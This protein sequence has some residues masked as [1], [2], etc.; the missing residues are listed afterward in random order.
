MESYLEALRP[1]EPNSILILHACAHNPTGCDPTQDQW[2]EI[3]AVV[4][5][6]Q[7]F[8]LFD[9]A[10]LGFRSG[11][12]DKDAFSIRHFVNGL[13]LETAIAVSFAKNMGFY[14]ERVGATLFVTSTEEVAHKCES[15]LERLQRSEISN[16][17][18]Y[19]AKIAAEILGDSLLRNMW[20][21]DFKTMSD[22]IAAMRTSL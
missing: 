11:N 18:A 2:K 4:K 20:F 22:R 5:E 17:P 19:G 15:M 8:P 10:Y 6:R 12:F 3:G 9:V 14:G 13:G 1:A 7:L 16:P 21:E